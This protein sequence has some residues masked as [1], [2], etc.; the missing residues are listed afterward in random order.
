MRLD[1]F[2]R[3]PLAFILVLVLEI[4]AD[5]HA[6]MHE[7]KYIYPG[8]VDHTHLRVSAWCRRVHHVI[9]PNVA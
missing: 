3:F 8:T 6:H 5:A 2:D 9:I 4:S 7:C 1:G